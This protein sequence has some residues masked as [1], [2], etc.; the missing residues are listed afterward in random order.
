L[1]SQSLPIH[2]LAATLLLTTCA[3]AQT[4]ITLRSVRDNTIYQ[5]SNGSLSNGA[6]EYLFAG[7]T[8]TG[9]IRRALVKFD[10]SA[11]PSNA[12]ITGVSLTLNVSR[13]ASGARDI[14]VHR[15]LREFGEG[16]S[17]A[18]GQEG[19][20]ATARTNDVTWLHTFWNTQ[21]WSTPG[22]DFVTTP[23]AI[24]TFSGLGPIIFDSEQLLADVRAWHARPSG[25]TGWIFRGDETTNTT[26]MRFDSREITG[27]ATAPKLTVTYTVPPPCGADFNADAVL[28]FFDYLD[29][30]RAYAAASSSADFNGDTNVDFFDYLD[31]VATFSA[32][33]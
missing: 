23:S 3:T 14:A 8:A 33:C 13:F 17:N 1:N 4:A 19:R 7:K 26:A 20:G 32:G 9:S 15:L 30:V 27:G 25:N 6:G 21:T 16:T 29:F 22:G 24:S 28:D 2:G 11:I 10:F 31:F 5:S 18:T 12:T